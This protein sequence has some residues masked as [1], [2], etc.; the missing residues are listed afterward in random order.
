MRRNETEYGIRPGEKGGACD[1]GNWN[2][3]DPPDVRS[4]RLLESPEKQLAYADME[5]DIKTVFNSMFDV[6]YSS[7]ANGVTRKVSNACE[8]IWGLRAADLVGRSVYELEK[9]GIYQPSVTRLVLETGRRIQTFQITKTGRKLAVVGTPIR[10]GAGNIIKV[11]NMSR[12]IISQADMLAEIDGL[13]QLVRAYRQEPDGLRF[14]AMT[15]DRFVYVSDAMDEVARMAAKV[16]GVDASALITGE[17][18]VGKEVIASF[19][20]ANSQR[21]EQP[22]I[23]INCGAIP[24]ALLESELFGY[25]AGAFTSAGK[26][27]KPGMFELAHKGTLFLDE[28]SEMPFAMQVKLLRVLQ[29]KVFMRVGGTKP[30]CVDVRI[31]AASNRDLETEV[32]EKRFRRDLFYR[33]NVVPIHIPALR[34]RPE[35]ILPLALFFLDRYNTRYGKNIVLDMEALHCL[36]TYSWHGNIRELQNVMERLVVLADAAIIGRAD[37]PDGIRDDF[38]REGVVVDRIMPLKEAIN[39]VERQ[40]LDMAAARYGSTTKIAEVL[41]VNQSTICRKLKRFS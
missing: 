21:K 19:I 40:L 6:V 13:G 29:D 24:E 7:D 26:A 20:H 3:E 36:E 11:V 25:E 12:E 34:E 4:G 10:D 15:D 38:C 31:I 1:S 32:L 14:L 33:L 2:A 28:I 37:L 41:G 39:S 17:S 22:F 8:K 30:V 16:A 18:G 35:D 9:D 5:L 23:R 27:G